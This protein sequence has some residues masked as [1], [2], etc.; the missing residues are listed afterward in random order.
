MEIEN[1]LFDNKRMPIMKEALSKCLDDQIDRIDILTAF[2]YFSG[3]IEL[4]KE[5]KNKKIRILV[6]KIIDPVLFKDL[7]KSVQAD[8][9]TSLDKYEL[10]GLSKFD[11]EALKSKY[12]EGFINMFNSAILSDEL[13]EE[14]NQKAFKIFLDKFKDGS[15]ELKLTM[16]P[17]HGKAYILHNKND[18]QNRGVVFT[19][20]S[21][22]SKNGLKL[23]GEL[24][25]KFTDNIYFNQYDKYFEECWENTKNI[26]F[27]TDKKNKLDFIDKIE[28]NLWIFS[29]P[30]PYHLYLRVLYEMFAHTDAL[31][32]KSASDLTNGKYLNLKYQN[33]AVKFGINCIKEHN[34]VIIAD[35]VGLG[36]TI[37][38]LTIAQ[39]LDYEET[40]IIAP[41]QISKQ[42]EEYVEEFRLRSVRIE[43]SGQISKL[44]KEY[45]NTE[46]KKLYIIDEAHRYRNENTKNYYY[47]HQLTRSHKDNKVILLTATPFTNKPDDLYSLIK[48]FQI[49]A[50]TT[51]N[52][53]SSF[54]KDIND[55]IEKYKIIKKNK[56]DNNDLSQISEKLGD[57]IR[58][59]TIRRSRLDLERINEYA[60]DLEIQNIK[61]PEVVGP[62]L[63][64]YELGS[65]SELYSNSL[66]KLTESFIASL[67]KHSSY[68]KDEK[69]FYTDFKKY[70]KNEKYMM[71]NYNI[72]DT[73][74]RLFVLRFESSKFSFQKTLE[75]LLKLYEATIESYEKKSCIY[76][77]KNNSDDFDEGD[78]RDGTDEIFEIDENLGETLEN[79]DNELNSVESVWNTKKHVKIPCSYFKE[80]Y[81]NDLKT[82]RDLLA[83]IQSSW[84][85]IFD[86]ETDPKLDEVSKNIKSFLNSED[87]RKLIIFSQ[88][89]DTVTYL[90][91]K[92]SRQFKSISF[93]GGSSKNDK[94]NILSE[95]DAQANTPTNDYNILITTDA[96]S[97]G[98]NLNRADIVINYDIP[99]AP[100]RV[101]QRIGRINRINNKTFDKLYVYNLFPS[102]IG[103]KNISIKGISTLKMYMITNAIGNDTKILTDDEELKSFIKK[104][105]DDEFNINKQS[106]E[107]EFRNIYNS[108]KANK[109]LIELIRKIPERTRILR[110]NNEKDITISF[111]KSG[112]N[113]AFSASEIGQD[114]ITPNC[115]IVNPEIALEYFKA[116]SNEIGFESNIDLT[117]CKKL[118]EKEL[119]KKDKT[120]KAKTNK[121]KSKNIQVLF[122]KYM[123]KDQIS[124]LN[125]LKDAFETYDDLSKYEMNFINNSMYPY[126][127]AN[128]L[129]LI[130][131]IPEKYLTHCKEKGNPS[132]K[133]TP[134]I[135]FT[136][137]LQ[138]TVD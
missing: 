69:K 11:D 19:G 63:L 8:N 68:L 70:F 52:D 30:K 102:E 132:N 84:Q 25:I 23:Q 126:K 111:A 59:I 121:S 73:I 60:N 16:E 96:L 13:D 72:A 58:P 47:L 28:K 118:L 99:Y 57:L 39:N 56:T 130:A 17:H 32:I 66:S 1:Y 34:G 117:Q 15:L 46:S 5:L 114:N 93:C 71:N 85:I 120:I 76:I 27:S 125:K 136:E 49:P 74:K 9:N 40:I 103:E 4:A 48:L 20:S 62:N 105:Y 104:Q 113:I 67:Y 29:T 138:K 97:E 2:F 110:K 95:F 127:K 75:K 109:E 7:E 134:I 81:F 86:G 91:K 123:D 107:V 90:Q 51:F 88:F 92:L 129:N 37:I 116:E 44:H 100:T 128:F 61:F 42:W 98:V 26:D 87:N 64:K 31:N 50:C 112:G 10:D 101:I 21:N 18:N 89:S 133:K 83:E 12:I 22:F 80:E 38:A 53:S 82:D 124:Y 45:F 54:Y 94:I 33:D 41:P 78:E 108:I 36:K 35:V 119:S 122:L 131:V 77:K 115:K 24:N 14:S 3:F 135:I 55:L 137:D 65:I 6:G 43:S 106:W 79:L